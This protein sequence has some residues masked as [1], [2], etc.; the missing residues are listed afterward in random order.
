VAEVSENEGD[1]PDAARVMSSA[2]FPLLYSKGVVLLIVLAY[3]SFPLLLCFGFVLV[4][5]HVTV[6]A[7]AQVL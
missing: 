2:S 3:F 7:S 5:F 1:S 4:F 6:F